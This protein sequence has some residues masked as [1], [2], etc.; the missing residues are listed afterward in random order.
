M[1]YRRRAMLIEPSTLERRDVVDLVNGLVAPRPIAWIST[2]DG[3]GA[4]N[5]A[6]FSFFNAFSTQ[7]PTVA[8]GPGSRQGVNKDTLRNI[9]ATRELDRKSVV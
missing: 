1:H 5:L 8:I 4:R 7:P 2:E 3:S 9:K 6:P